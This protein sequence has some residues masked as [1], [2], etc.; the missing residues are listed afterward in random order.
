MKAWLAEHA[1]ALRAA[2]A[3]LRVNPLGNL[4]NVL[5]I[6]IALSLPATLYA[7]L[8][9]LG[10]WSAQRD[11]RPRFSVFV[12]Q[13]ASEKASSEIATKLKAHREI[14]AV[15]ALPKERALKVLEEKLG[16]GNVAAALGENPLPDAF[17]AH[18]KSSDIEVLSSLRDEIARWP[19][20]SEVLWDAEWVKKLQ[21]IV[22]LGEFAVGVLAVLLGFGVLAVT[23]NTVRLQVMTQESEIEV[24][25][26]IG[27]TRAYI[28]RPFLYFGALQGLVAGLV[29]CGIVFAVVH[30][31]QTKIEP[32]NAL[33]GAQFVLA[34]PPPVEALTALAAAAALGW[35]GALFSVRRHLARADPSR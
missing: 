27:A 35:L 24:A 23:F 18:A 6:A 1:H 29:C 32:V 30:Y 7:G 4:F 26:L 22:R 5:A 19:G 3:K 15:E 10:Q 11:D 12:A 21:A 16:L 28:R 20:V 13:D 9:S 25:G 2:W 33:Y 31:L 8:V 34:L 17:V 14:A